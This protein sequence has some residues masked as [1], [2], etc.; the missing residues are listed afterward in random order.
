M[1]DK[2]VKALFRQ[3]KHPMKDR[4]KRAAVG[5][6]NLKECGRSFKRFLLPSFPRPERM[7]AIAILSSGGTKNPCVLTYCLQVTP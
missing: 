1:S 4:A 3:H 7:V 5:S 2:I 6:G